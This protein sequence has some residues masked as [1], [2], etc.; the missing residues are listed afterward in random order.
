MKNQI[1]LSQ[2]TVLAFAVP[3]WKWTTDHTDRS[4][5]FA[6]LHFKL[7]QLNFLHV[8]P[9]TETRLLFRCFTA[10]IDIG[11]FESLREQ[12]MQSAANYTFKNQALFK[13]HSCG[14]PREDAFH[15]FRDLDSD[16][17]WP[18]MVGGLT[19]LALNAWC[20]DQVGLEIATE[21]IPWNK[22]K[23]FKKDGTRLAGK[24]AARWKVNVVPRKLLSRPAFRWLRREFQQH[25][26]RPKHWAAKMG[27]SKSPSAAGLTSQ[28]SHFRF[29]FNDLCQQRQWHMPRQVSCWQHTSRC[30][31]SSFS[32][33]PEWSAEFTI[34][35]TGTVNSL[36]EPK[37]KT[38]MY[39]FS[40][41]HCTPRRLFPFLDEVACAHPNACR[42]VCENP[43]GCSDLAYPLLV[44]RVLPDGKF[45]PSYDQALKVR[46]SQFQRHFGSTWPI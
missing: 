24:E 19:I 30:C 29:V 9:F 8:F 16:Y 10:M 11:G 26:D 4:V 40:R 46:V 13:N 3:F 5:G 44:I 22:T 15:I 28:P 45:I 17:P 18:G 27:K 23:L 34:Q 12:Y 2:K 31:P 21:K 6:V 42:E 36:L 1:Y 14:M 41:C 33:C 32:W 39:D 43:S 25:S 20:T 38:A 7:A 37:S 35:V